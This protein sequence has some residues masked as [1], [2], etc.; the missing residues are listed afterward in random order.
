[1]GNDYDWKAL[2]KN[3]PYCRPIFDI[4]FGN[5]N[6]NVLSYDPGPGTLC[7]GKK[8]GVLNNAIS[9]PTHTQSTGIRDIFAGINI[10]PNVMRPSLQR[11]EPGSPA[12]QPTALTTR[13]NPLI[14]GKCKWSKIM[15]ENNP[16]D[17]PQSI[18]KINKFGDLYSA[19]PSPSGRL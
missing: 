4:V 18:T 6:W 9:T 16:F 7:K 12:Y 5:G 14:E 19:Y 13:P 1:M 10:H 17:R 11:V 8:L 3:S 2:V 15:M